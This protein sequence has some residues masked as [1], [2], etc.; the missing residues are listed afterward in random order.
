MHPEVRRGV[1]STRITAV[2]GGI[3]T[4][5][6][7]RLAGEEPME[8]RAGGLSQEPV[9]VAVTMRTPGH[10]FE[11]AS[12]FL[13][14]EGLIGA[15]DIVKVSYCDTLEVDQEFNVVTVR[16]S[17]P[18]EPRAQRNF[19]ATSSCGI[20][21]KASL[22][23][24]EVMC[25]QVPAGPTVA[26]ST[27]TALPEDMR[28]AQKTFNATGGLHAAG[29]FDSSG[30]LKVVRE[31]VGRHNA[32]DKLVG[33]AV[34]AGSLLFGHILMVSGRTSFEIVQKAAVAGAPIVCAV[35][36]P[37]SLAVEAAQRFGLTLIGFL[38]GD[39]FNIYTHPERI[40]LSA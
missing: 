37:S 25:G 5:R 36:A 24:V 21:G 30:S 18:F 14:T 8:I 13:F 11:L 6:A 31:D 23:E 27:I 2:R 32:V 26:R 28:A 29:L 15:D 17:R 22:D 16:L 7:D 4:Q 38:R 34:L 3:S 35:S 19:Y 1:S 9:A 33:K 10:D 20:C 12:G 39:G 40:D